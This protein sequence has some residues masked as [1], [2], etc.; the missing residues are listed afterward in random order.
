MN[1]TRTMFSAVLGLLLFL[2][3]LSAWSTLDAEV[4]QNRVEMSFKDTPI[5]DVYKMLSLQHGINIVL[6]DDVGGNVS[7]NLYDITLDAAIAS[8]AESSGFVAERRGDTFVI[9]DRDESGKDAVSDN[10]D[11]SATFVE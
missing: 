8:I 1:T 6:S 4:S 7:L 2:T 9:V 3:P 11:I 5:E 10:T